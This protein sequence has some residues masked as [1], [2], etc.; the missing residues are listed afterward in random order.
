[1]FASAFA[2]NAESSP[3]AFAKAPLEE[4]RD[5]SARCDSG[6]VTHPSGRS[7]KKGLR[8]G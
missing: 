8:N 1:M 2:F 5:H 4:R 6:R 3:L 7:Y